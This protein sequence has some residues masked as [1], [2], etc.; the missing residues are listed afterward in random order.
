[1]TEIPKCQFFNQ[2]GEILLRFQKYVAKLYLDFENKKGIFFVNI[3]TEKGI[4]TKK[5]VVK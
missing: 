1:M 5:I 4:Q 2:F 3:Y